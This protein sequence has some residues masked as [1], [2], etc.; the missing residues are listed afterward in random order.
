M[1][2]SFVNEMPHEWKTEPCLGDDLET[3]VHMNVPPDDYMLACHVRVGRQQ[4]RSSF[5]RTISPVEMREIY[6]AMTKVADFDNCCN[7]Y[8]ICDRNYGSI[9]SFYSQLKTEYRANRNRAGG[10]IDDTVLEMNR[11]LLNYLASFKTFV[12]HLKTRYSRLPSQKG[13]YLAD[14]NSICSACF[15]T[16]FYYRFFSKLRDYVQHCGLPVHYVV[17]EET[18]G[19]LDISMGFDRDLLMSH[20]KKWGPV[21]KDLIRQPERFEVI[22]SLGKLRDQIQLINTAVTCIELSIAYD[23]CNRLCGLINE[24]AGHYPDGEPFIGRL[25]RRGTAK[26]SLEMINFPY[27]QMRRFHEKH[28]GVR[29][30]GSGIKLPRESQN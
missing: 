17:I 25:A 15:D 1:A 29:K 11:L 3:V 7:L 24:V 22:P 16:D 14:F 6:D 2:Q 30:S 19:R 12:D 18:P 13:E 5:I 28:E 27:H 8:E 9:L 10:F 21:R 26:P 20:F 4:I 23:S